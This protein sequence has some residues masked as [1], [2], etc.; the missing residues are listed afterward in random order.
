MIKDHHLFLAIVGVFALFVLGVTIPNL[1]A[2]TTGYYVKETM[3]CEPMSCSERG[4]GP[5]GSFYCDKNNCYR[6]CY[7]DGE[8]IEMA[9]FCEKGLKLVTE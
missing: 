5:G 7:Q 4:L 6:D 9:T 3:F 1:E 2:S 8:L